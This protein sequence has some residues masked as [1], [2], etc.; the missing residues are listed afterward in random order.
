M[1]VKINATDCLIGLTW[2]QVGGASGDVDFL[3]LFQ[4]LCVEQ[5]DGGAL[6]EGHPNPPT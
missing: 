6:V 4:G 2:C 3:Q 5:V 1:T